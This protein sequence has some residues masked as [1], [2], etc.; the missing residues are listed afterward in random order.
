MLYKSWISKSCGFNDK[1]EKLHIQLIR[2]VSIGF[3]YHLKRELTGMN[4]LIIPAILAA[5]VLVAGMFAILPV[6]KVSTVHNTILAVLK[7]LTVFDVPSGVPDTTI[8]IL[9]DGLGNARAADLEFNGNIATGPTE[10][11]LEFNDGPAPGVWTAVVFG[12]TA[13]SQLSGASPTGVDHI[14]RNTQG[15]RLRCADGGASGVCE[16]GTFV[17]VTVVGI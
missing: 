16:T 15:L 2:S 12:T 13:G 3:I 8:I 11:V 14:D 9:Y 5:T 17:S 6:Q 1:I 4:K 7:A 10:W